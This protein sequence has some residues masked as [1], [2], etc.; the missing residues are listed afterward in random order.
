MAITLDHTKQ[1]LDEAEIGW[2]EGPE[3]TLLF[4]LGD[5][6]EQLNIVLDLPSEGR[7]VQLRTVKMLMAPDLTHRNALLTALL[8]SNDK[9]KLIKFAFDPEDGEVC[10]YVDLVLGEASL[11]ERQFLRCISSLQH[12]AGNGLGRFRE[13]VRSGEDP[14]LPVE[15]APELMQAMMALDRGSMSKGNGAGGNGHAGGADAALHEL[16]KKR[17]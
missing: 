4:R 16:T 15:M 7:I 9:L 2:V 12:M 6:E 11:T 14:G 8:S 3:Q 5:G 13:I 1:M 10:A 17:D